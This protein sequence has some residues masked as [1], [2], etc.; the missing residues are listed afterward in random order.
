MST[1]R[2]TLRSLALRPGFTALVVGTLAVAIGAN[3]AIFSVLHGVVL[4][5]LPYAEPDEL[6]MVWERNPSQG[7]EQSTTSAATFVDW[8]ERSDAFESMAAYRYRGYTL[9]LDG[10][11]QRIASLETSPALFPLLGVDPMLGRTFTPEEEARGNERLV[12]LSHGAWQNRFGA[13]PSVVGTSIP[14][15]GEPHTVVGVMPAGFAFPPGDTDVEAWSPLT[16]DLENLLSRPHRMYNTVGRLGDGVTEGQARTEMEAV[17]GELARLH[18]DS[19]E[20]WSVALVSA[21]DQLLG[22]TATTVWV[23]FGAVTLVLLIG[24]V[25]VANLLLVRSAERSKAVAVSSALGATPAH[26][27]RGA[28]LEGLVLGAGGGLAGL[29]VAWGGA[30]LLRGV[31]PDGFPRVE[32]IGID[33]AVVAFT[34]GVA[35]LSSVLFSLAPAVRT[36]GTDVASV[37]QDA[38]RGSSLGRRS[39]RLAGFMVASE[40]ALALVLMVGAGLLLRSYVGL[41]AVDPGFR[42]RDVVAVAIE[43]PPARYATSG[44]QEAFFAELMSGLRALPAAEEVGAVSYLPMSPIGVEFDMPF[45]VEGLEVASPSQRPTA[46]YRAVFPR[47]FEAMGIRLVEGRFLDALDGTDDRKVVLV[48]ETVARRYF[49]DRSPIGQVI[50]MPMAGSLEIVGVVGDIRHDGLG[51]QAN[52]E[53][54]VPY[55]QLPLSAM[56]VVVHTRGDPGP[57]VRAIRERI[58]AVDPAQPVTRVNTMEDLLAGSVAPSRFNMVLLLGLASCAVL[59]AVVGVYGVVS[60]TVSRRTRELGV[61]MALGA[62]AGSAVGLVLSQALRVVAGGAA[63]GVGV[64]LASA[65]VLRGL[66]YGVEPV[67]PATYAVVVALTLG[68]GILA[69]AVPAVRAARVDPVEALRAE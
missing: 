29:V 61:R 22:D 38:G 15:D 8:R 63:V 40:V 24:C 6:F 42:T 1:L 36:A 66:L 53:M 25:N 59:L 54:F 18:P 67:D 7:L 58:R 34:A 68:V 49:R 43:L 11:P 28:L 46:E 27:V 16:L 31:L 17:A 10:V 45:S 19:N 69:A 4:E 33:P 62:G 32:E 56:H 47:Y 30:A 44:Q 12:I 13:D 20:G 52:P 5:P 35:V 37:L 2:Q 23:L 9:T 41:T 21:R 57:A 64:S 65:R 60:Y 39:R 3:S 55:A 51:A 14:L 26:L 48:N 50:D